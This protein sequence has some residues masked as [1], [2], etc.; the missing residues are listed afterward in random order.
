M[1]EPLWY[2][3]APA[4]FALADVEVVAPPPRLAGAAALWL[5]GLAAVPCDCAEAEPD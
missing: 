3:E 5:C 2:P 4:G 1:A